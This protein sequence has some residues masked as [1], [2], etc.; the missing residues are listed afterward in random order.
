MKK[1]DLIEFYSIHKLKIFPLIVS[2]S[3]LFL[4]IFVIYPQVVKLISNQEA[5][6]SLN[7][8]S[9]LL[10]TKVIALQSYD[11]EELSRKLGIILESLP[12]DKDYGN[13][14]GLLQ[15]LT[16][17]S[18]FSANLISFTKGTGD[19]AG[20]SNYG[21]QMSVKGFRDNFQT[22]L[23]SLENSSRLVR[24]NK[25]E[26]SSRTNSP[27]LESSLGIEALYE[28]MP[29]NVGEV[30]SSLPEFSQKDEELIKELAEL[31]QAILATSSSSAVQ[32]PRGK[33]NPFE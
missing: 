5:I 2:L 4:S 23:D 7:K 12:P 22:L 21:V 29:K 3:S 20:V 31:E 10:E 28:G 15:R 33:S 16:V 32:S 11:I 6:G 18:G 19:G 30:D 1:K 17:N 9:Q 24:I 13:I 8:K 14:L 26:V 27:T 25:I